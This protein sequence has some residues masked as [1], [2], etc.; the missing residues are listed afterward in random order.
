MYVVDLLAYLCFSHYESVKE[1]RR[2]AKQYFLE[3]KDSYPEL[4]QLCHTI[5]SYKGKKVWT[6]DVGG[7]FQL[8]QVL[9]GSRAYRFREWVSCQLL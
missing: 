6:I 5:T 4:L 2:G 8:F 1:A 3:L 9:K 7:V